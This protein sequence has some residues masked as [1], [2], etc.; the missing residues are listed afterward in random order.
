MEMIDG[1]GANISYNPCFA[2]FSTINGVKFLSLL[3]LTTI[4]LYISVL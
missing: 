3:T 1:A 4:Y 2:S